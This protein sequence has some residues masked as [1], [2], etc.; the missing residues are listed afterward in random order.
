MKLDTI[1][2]FVCEV[3]NG[4]YDICDLKWVW[5]G[6]NSLQDTLY[7]TSWRGLIVG[8]TEKRQKL[9]DVECVCSEAVGEG[10]EVG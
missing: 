6:W 7:A 8:E 10:S 4:Y 5:F 9:E 2:R 1:R 3:M